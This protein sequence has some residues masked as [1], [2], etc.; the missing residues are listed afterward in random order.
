MNKQDLLKQLNLEDAFEGFTPDKEAKIWGWNGATNIFPM[1]VNEVKPKQIIETGSWMGQSTCTFAKSIH[2]ANLQNECSVISVDTWLGSLE[3]WKEQDLKPHLKLKHG[4]PTYYDTYLSNVVNSG[5]KE[6]ILPLCM[7]PSIGAQ[8][9]REHGVKA[10]LIYVD[11]SHAEQDVYHDL[12][13]FW[14]LLEPGGVMFGDDLP[15]E[16]VKTGAMAFSAEVGTPL[17]VVGN[18]YW[19]FKKNIN[20]ET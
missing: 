7:T 18:I 14:P 20:D 6:T 12:Q 16:S 1:L 8:F 11:G 10:Q 3:H 4:R 17:A 2:E 9:L 15:W 13:A 5:F 19:L